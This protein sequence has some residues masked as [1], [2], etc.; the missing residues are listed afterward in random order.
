MSLTLKTHV[1]QIQEQDRGGSKIYTVRLVVD[2]DEGNCCPTG[3]ERICQ[4]SLALPKATCDD[5]EIGQVVD[6]TLVPAT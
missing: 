3:Q 5:L 6:I 4:L 1:S 2:A